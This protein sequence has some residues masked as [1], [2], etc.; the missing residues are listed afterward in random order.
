M[1]HMRISS[2][3]ILTIYFEIG[4]QPQEAI[5]ITSLWK[6]DEGIKKNACGGTAGRMVVHMHNYLKS[7]LG[8][9]LPNFQKKPQKTALYL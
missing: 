7:N 3:T 1:L 4:W 2:V 8:H 5:C 9:F 6:E